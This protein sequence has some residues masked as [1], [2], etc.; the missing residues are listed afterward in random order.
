MASPFVRVYDASRDF[1]NGLHVFFTTIDQGLDWEPARTIGSYLWYKA[2]VSLAPSTCMVL[3][4]GSGRV[5][6]YCIGTAETRCFAQEWRNTFAKS[7]DATL[8][9]RPETKSHDPAMEQDLVRNFRHA[10]YNGE[11]SMLL[12]WPEALEKYPAHMHIDILPEYQRKGYGT[13]LISAFFEAVKGLGAGGVHLDMVRTN[14]A[15]RA[16]Y[17]RIGFR[18]CEQVLD[19]G[20]SG[21]TGVND[22][23]VTLVKDL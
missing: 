5:I 3:D 12:P 8:V 20:V 11:C 23:V 16:F 14:S 6:G 7:I 19:G 2:Y 1:D 13:V 17:T 21:E 10:L 18:V 22:V 9:P 15:G 4:D